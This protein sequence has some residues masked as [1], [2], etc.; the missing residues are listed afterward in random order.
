[1]ANLFLYL[2]VYLRHIFIRENISKIIRNFTMEL[3]PAV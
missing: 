3:L 2:P 1:V